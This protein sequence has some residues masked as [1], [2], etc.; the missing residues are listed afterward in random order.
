MHAW[1]LVGDMNLV[2]M[3]TNM[4]WQFLHWPSHILCESMASC[5]EQSVVH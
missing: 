2:A 3:S 5:D 1:I 4:M